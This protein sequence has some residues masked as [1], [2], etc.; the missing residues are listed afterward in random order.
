[1]HRYH[2]L[3]L[4]ISVC[5]YSSCTKE[6]PMEFEKA[7]EQLV[8]LAYA[9]PGASIQTIITKTYLIDEYVGQNNID[10]LNLP[11][12]L[13]RNNIPVDTF[14][15]NNGTHY[16]NYLPQAN[17]EL[18]IEI[19]NGNTT[20][21]AQTKIPMPV[22]IN[23]FNY[24]ADDFIDYE[25]TKLDLITF[26]FNDDP[27]AV[28][29]YEIYV[30]QTI[31]TD[32]NTYSYFPYYYD[33]NDPIIRNED[34][35][36]FEPTTLLFSDKLFNGTTASISFA[37]S[38]AYIKY[39][40]TIVKSEFF[41]IAVSESYYNYQKA[42]YKHIFNKSSDSFWISLAEP[43]PVYTGIKNGLGLFCGYNVSSIEFNVNE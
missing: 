10:K 14:Y 9:S 39:N 11:I 7:A 36:S 21:V 37:F 5:F 42:Y 29:Y 27:Q 20:L 28:N 8:V 24:K 43:V 26:E 13:Y 1:M 17:D 22:N 6:V 4:I 38:C 3:L 18:G 40:E 32:S 2:L 25:G 41:L 31:Q 23:S 15:Y 30:K 19:I 35:L 12:K 16:S 34:I 33:S